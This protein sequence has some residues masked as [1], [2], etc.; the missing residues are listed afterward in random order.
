MAR[1]VLAFV[2]MAASASPSRAAPRWGVAGFGGFQTYAMQDVTDAIDEAGG[3]FGSP[4]VVL[5]NNIE[6]GLSSG[7][8]V[9]ALLSPK[10]GLALDY[11]RLSGHSDLSQGGAGNIHFGVSANVYSLTASYSPWRAGSSRVGLSAGIGLYD[12]HA[13]ANEDVPYAA[14]DRDLSYSGSDLGF[15]V[16][17]GDDIRLSPQLRLEMAAGYRWAKVDAGLPQ[18]SG[19]IDWSG[20]ASRLGLAWFP[21]GVLAH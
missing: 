6:N 7:A 3:L 20:F 10:L 11:E 21:K 9:R 15:H 18:G 8:G 14:V 17:A 19:Q 5:V 13:S 4:D 2:L 16:M 12:S 1:F